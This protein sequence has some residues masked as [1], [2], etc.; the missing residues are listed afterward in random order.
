MLVALATCFWKTGKRSATPSP[1]WV[2][3]GGANETADASG[4]PVL[5]AVRSWPSSLEHPYRSFASFTNLWLLPGPAV[6][7][8]NPNDVTTPTRPLRFA[9]P[10]K[11]FMIPSAWPTQPP[12]IHCGGCV[13]QRGGGGTTGPCMGHPGTHEMRFLPTRCP[14]GGSRSCTS[15]PRAP[16]AGSPIGPSQCP[17]GVGTSS[18]EGS[19]KKRN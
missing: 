2:G 13:S 7:P 3:K 1:V 4:R 19:E 9:A 15:W 10:K 11:A 18:R 12:V 8:P 14:W 6:N 16:L 17:C 5:P